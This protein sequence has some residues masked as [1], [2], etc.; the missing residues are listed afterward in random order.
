MNIIQRRNQGSNTLD[1]F[2]R[3][4]QNVVSREWPSLLFA[5]SQGVDQGTLALDVSENDEQVIVRASLPGFS[6]DSVNVEL[7]DGVLC[8]TAEQSEEHEDKGER[9]F[10]RERRTGSLS[11]RIAL[12]GVASDD[13]ADA[14]LVDG[15]LT[16]TVPK[17]RKESPRKVE[18]K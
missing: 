7:H 16:V 3:M 6:K 4:F 2:D 1:V 10:R 5:D 18:I 14:Q 8:I 15:I 17:A 9:Y 11:R 12:P 13:G